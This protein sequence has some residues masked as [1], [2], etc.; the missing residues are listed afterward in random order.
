LRFVLS[1]D[2]FDAFVSAVN[3][4]LRLFKYEGLFDN[5]VPLAQMGIRYQNEGDSDSYKYLPLSIPYD[6]ANT[7]AWLSA[8]GYYDRLTAWRASVRSLRLN[9]VTRTK[10]RSGYEE[11]VEEV[12]VLRDPALIRAA[13]D[14]AER[15]ILDSKDHWS[16]IFSMPPAEAVVSDGAGEASNG[17]AE[18]SAAVGEPEAAFSEYANPENEIVLHMN[19]GNPALDALLAALGEES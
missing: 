2:A 6:F 5:A 17:A 3:A 9:H 10:G 16:L 8:N 7:V 19:P 18:A 11:S 15:M 13:L 14:G 12:A 4:D 1:S